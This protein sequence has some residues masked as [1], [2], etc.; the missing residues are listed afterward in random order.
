MKWSFIIPAHNSSKYIADL[1]DSIPRRDDL[2][3]IVVDDHSDEGEVVS[4]R[5]LLSQANFPHS[6][7]LQNTGVNSAGAARNLGVSSSSGQWIIF[8][9]SDDVFETESL[10]RAMK[11]YDDSDSDL[12]YFCPYV[13]GRD[14]ELVR[15]YSKY[16]KKPSTIE[17]TRLRYNIPSVWSKFIHRDL[18][19][20]GGIRAEEVLV[21]ND[22]M[23]STK[24]AFFA[25]NLTMDGS[26]RL[27]RL[28]YREGSLVTGRSLDRYLTREGVLIRRNSFLRERL[29]VRDFRIAARSRLMPVKNC[30]RLHGPVQALRS[31]RRLR[32]AGV[33]VLIVQDI[34]STMRWTVSALRGRSQK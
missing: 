31:Y 28:R 18:I 21:A 25:R 22:W 27:Y 24:L 4:T 9:D 12:V 5:E 29:D 23:M 11:K 30:L 19:E 2:E 3:V 20:R 17:F 10:E 34:A 16:F 13:E 26:L 6:I 14:W 1:F 7:F 15:R 32:S 33:P 8:A